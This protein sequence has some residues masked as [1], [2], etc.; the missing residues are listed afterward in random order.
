M[1]RRFLL[2]SFILFSII[3][4]ACAEQPKII[5]RPGYILYIP[6]KVDFN[7]E[8]PLIVALSPSADS[9]SMINL[10]KNIAER[11][12]LIVFA[13]KVFRNGVSF[14]KQEVKIIPNLEQAISEFPIDK[15][16]MIFTGFSGGGM[17]S[18][19]FAYEHPQLVAAVVVNTCMIHEYY[20]ERKDTYPKNKLAVFLASPTDFRYDEM[21]HDKNFLE[22]LGWKTKWIEFKGGHRIAPAEIYNEAI[23]WL[24][25]Q[26]K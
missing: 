11:H 21:K 4:L 3:S 2:L 15:S 7:Q 6:S 10:W 12:K 26:F 20:I 5:D 9:Q 19:M 24:K 25:E 13:C 23:N 17:G 1:I 16:K 14:D 22:S 8:Y 18:H